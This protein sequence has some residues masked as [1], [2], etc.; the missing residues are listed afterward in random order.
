[1]PRSSSQHRPLPPRAGIGLRARHHAEFVETRPPVA[2]IEVP[3]EN[4]FRR[5]RPLH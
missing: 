5:G 1:M 2:F 4:Y 3:S